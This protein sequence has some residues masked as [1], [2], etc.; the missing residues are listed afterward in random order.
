MTSSLAESPL[1]ECT[2]RG[3]PVA[4]R[5]SLRGVAVA[6]LSSAKGLRPPRASLAP[7]WALRGVA[8]AG[9]ERGLPAWAEC[10]LRGPERGSERGVADAGPERGSDRG[11][12]DAGPERGSDRGVAEAGPDLGVV[13]CG[14]ALPDGVVSAGRPASFSLFTGVSDIGGAL[15]DGVR[16]PLLPLRAP[17]APLRAPDVL[18]GL[19]VLRGCL[20]T[21]S[22]VILGT[23]DVGV[24]LALRALPALRGL[25]A[26]RS[27]EALRGFDALR[28]L[29][30]FALR[31][32]GTL[33]SSS[34]SSSS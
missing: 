7:E 24:R 8:D 5:S 12:A 2:L 3:V 21:P 25:D 13:V 33:G 9:P 16:S 29:D 20:C 6:G 31:V 15:P 30:V 14:G 28:G 34:S 11:V 1:L 27:P 23:G 10:S 22:E 26:L 32:L 19:D 18:R 4:A 17:D